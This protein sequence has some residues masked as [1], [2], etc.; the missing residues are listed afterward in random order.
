MDQ[1]DDSDSSIAAPLMLV[2]CLLMGGDRPASLSEL[3]I[4]ER[5]LYDSLRV[6]QWA[7]EREIVTRITGI[8]GEDDEATLLSKLTNLNEAAA[9]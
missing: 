2:L 5:A 8:G 4:S 7:V 3:T 1:Q 9:A 6:Y